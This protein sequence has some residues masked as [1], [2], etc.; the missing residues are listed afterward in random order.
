MPK[1]SDIERRKQVSFNAFYFEQNNLTHLCKMKDIFQ[2]INDINLWG[3]TESIS[4][5]GS[6]A[7]QTTSLK[8]DLQRLLQTLKVATLLDAPC[9]DFGWLS[10]VG[11]NVQQYIGVD[12]IESI[13]NNHV[14]SYKHDSRFKFI[15]GDLTQDVLPTADL[16]L[17]RDCLVH[18]SN[19]A[20]FQ[21]L[22]NFKKTKNRYLLTTT[23][24]DCK[25]NVDIKTGDWRPINLEMAP[26][27]FPKSIANIIEGCTEANGLYSDKSL[28]LW[29]IEKINIC[30][31]NIT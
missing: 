10:E 15:L 7:Q 28:G 29:E 9:G 19:E 6:S 24:I 3:S 8:L 25:E 31:R 30:W 4:G 22:R 11:L 26:F 13:V 21:A 27:H 16:I 17:C 23:F 5:N 2:H 14:Q 20:I 18:F 12:I 1:L